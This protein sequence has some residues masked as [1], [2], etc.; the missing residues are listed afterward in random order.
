LET[1]LK[2]GQVPIVPA[3]RDRIGGG[4]RL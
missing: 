1:R 4:V 3:V 2:I